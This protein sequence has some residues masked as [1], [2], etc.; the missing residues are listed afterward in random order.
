MFFW[1]KLLGIDDTH[2]LIMNKARDKEV[3]LVPGSA[4]NVDPKE[5]SQ[6]VRASYSLG[7]DEQ[8]WEVRIVRK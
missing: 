7:T 5:P 8:I 6:Y 1:M 3:L 4:F 2:D